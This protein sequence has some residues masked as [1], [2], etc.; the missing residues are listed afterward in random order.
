[1]LTEDAIRKYYIDKYPS[2][3]VPTE[4]AENASVGAQNQRFL[5]ELHGESVKHGLGLTFWLSVKDSTNPAVLAT[6]LERYPTGEFSA[7]ARTLAD[8][9][10]RKL[11]AEQAA[12]EEERKRLENERKAAEVKRL[13]EGRRV[14]EAV[15]A[16]EHKRAQ[17]AKGAEEQRLLEEQHGAELLKRT[18]ELR[19]ALEEARLAREAAKLAEAQRVAAVKAVEA[20][21][22]AANDAIASKRDSE[23]HSDPSKVAALPKL[24]QPK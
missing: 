20:A 17:L 10:D 15:I 3:S 12:Q 23:H 19:K 7:I 16:E 1:M 2:I 14:R 24:E 22:K 13:E 5:N 18:E 9:Y 6:Y 8:H 11:K 21:T 4:V